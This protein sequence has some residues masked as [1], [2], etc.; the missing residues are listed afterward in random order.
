[1]E[2]IPN[3]R[4]EFISKGGHACSVTNPLEFNRIAADFLM[5]QTAGR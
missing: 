4:L 5:Q 3:A 2:H 1:V